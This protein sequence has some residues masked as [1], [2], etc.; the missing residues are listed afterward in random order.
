MDQKILTK[1]STIHCV[2]GNSKIDETQPLAAGTY[3]W[4]STSWTGAWPTI[5]PSYRSGLCFDNSRKW[6]ALA[7]RST[8]MDAH[9]LSEQNRP[10]LGH[11]RIREIFWASV[12]LLN[13]LEYHN[14]FI[15]FDQN[16]SQMFN[17]K[18]RVWLGKIPIACFFSVILSKR[19]LT[20]GG[21][22]HHGCEALDCDS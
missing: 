14:Y 4:L 18:D 17:Y 6:A 22:L 7:C 1:E 10:Q 13:L 16:A 19:W 5:Y 11:H 20:K 8:R 9:D 2:K 3:L 15:G 12:D 21:K